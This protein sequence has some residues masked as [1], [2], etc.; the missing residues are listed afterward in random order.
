MSAAATT[1]AGPHSQ[2]I[3]IGTR[4]SALAMWQAKH[5][6]ALLSAAYPAIK[7]ESKS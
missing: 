3:R 6:E 1:E 2:V 5:V 4:E 7:F